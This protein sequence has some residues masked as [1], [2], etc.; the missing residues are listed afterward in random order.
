MDNNNNKSRQNLPMVQTFSSSQED[1]SNGCELTSMS[2]QEQ[3]IIFRMHK[4]VGDK[5]ELIAGRIPGRTAQEI[6]RF[7]RN[8][9]TFKVNRVPQTARK[10]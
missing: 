7:W 3:D 4:L 8:C 2:E 9:D 6:E 10:K 1:R 5:W